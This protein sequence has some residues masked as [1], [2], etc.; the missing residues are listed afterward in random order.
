MTALATKTMNNKPPFQIFLE[1]FASKVDKLAKQNDLPGVKWEITHPSDHLTCCDISID[2]K[3]EDYPVYRMTSRMIEDEDEDG[4]AYR[5]IIIRLTNL[6]DNH[7][8][9]VKADPQTVLQ[10]ISF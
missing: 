7:C 3:D 8:H 5:T 4:C 6:D 9:T 10:I 2:D 1:N